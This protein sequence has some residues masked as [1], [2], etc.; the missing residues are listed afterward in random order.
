MLPDAT[1][2][3]FHLARALL[4][5]QLELGADEPVGDVPVNRYDLPAEV[6]KP[7]STVLASNAMLLPK[8]RLTASVH[9]KAAATWKKL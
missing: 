1:K 4:A 3:D 2:M 9:G 5:W 6:P 7:L 8:G